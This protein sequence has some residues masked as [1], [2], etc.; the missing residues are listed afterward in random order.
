MPSLP[1]YQDLI[2]ATKALQERL[3]A[4]A[5]SG[6]YPSLLERDLMREQ[7]RHLYLLLDELPVTRH[8]EP[9]LQVQ[10]EATRPD[11]F[12]SMVATREPATTLRMESS[13]HT[14]S[15][16]QGEIQEVEILIEQM[17]PAPEAFDDEPEL[18]ASDPMPGLRAITMEQAGENPTEEHSLSTWADRFHAEESLG[19]KIL[20]EHP[21][22]TLSDSLRERTL[23]DLHQSIGV[24]ERFSFINGLF[25]G[26]QLKYFSAIDELNACTSVEAAMQFIQ[27]DMRTAMGWKKDPPV[28]ADF[29]DLVRRR[30]HD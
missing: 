20:K 30:F 27:Q 14:P 1:G 2:H 13:D 26:D 3:H 9:M 25:K 10:T 6:N 21:A 7:L 18:S 23:S 15:V 8:N 22:R 28:L 11:V 5:D 17:T 29:I 19:E 24:N 4:C 12:E 16:V